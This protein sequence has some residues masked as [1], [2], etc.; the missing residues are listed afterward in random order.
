MCGV[1]GEQ[2]PPLAVGRGLPGRVGE[3]GDPGGAVDPVVGPVHGDESLAEVA[4]GGFARRSGV[5]FG[6]HDLHRPL[7]RE[8]HLT[9]ADL[10]LHPADGV[11]AD[12]VPADAQFRLPGH[13]DLGDQAAGGRIPPGELDAG[14][15]TD[16]AASSVAPDE[17]L[18]PQRPTVGHHD[19]DAGVVLSEPR[20]LT[21]PMDRHR[22]LV[23]PAS[24]YALDV[25]LPQ[26]EPIGVPGGKVADVERTAGEKC[27]DLSHL[28]LRDEPLGDSALIENL[29]RA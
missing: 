24:Q 6:H 28:P 23:D 3:P 17:V 15:L 2:D 13:L 1:A 10:V 26:P 11:G 29:D 12:L 14:R 19:V 4:Q 22:K 16:E 7:V 21:S 20:H 27:S 8:D 18:R 25:V 9:V 5:R